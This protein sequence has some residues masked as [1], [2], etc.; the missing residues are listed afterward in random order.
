MI[1][2]AS[3]YETLIREGVDFFTGVP[4]SLLK[5]KDPAGARE[6]YLA[7]VGRMAMRWPQ[8]TEGPR[9]RAGLEVAYAPET[10][11]KA[12]GQLNGA[13]DLEGLAWD[14]VASIMEFKPGHSI[15]LNYGRTGAG[16]L[17]SP[18]FRPNEE[19]VE[20]RYQW[21]HEDWPLLEVR[22]RQ[23][24]EIDKLLGSTR[25]RSVF[26]YYARLTWQF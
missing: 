3:F 1:D 6:D 13:G 7:F 12:A 19:L 17:L 20:I 25:K 23:R 15:G 24:D 22:V 21:K 2:S 18:Q 8:R 14:I 10:P 5:D 16:W 26:D 9:L 4:D 11:T